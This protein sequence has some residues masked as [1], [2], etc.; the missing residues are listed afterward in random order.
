MGCGDSGRQTIIQLR[1]NMKLK[2]ERC[3]KK[4][5]VEF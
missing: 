4:K 5:T 3:I 1:Q 2:L